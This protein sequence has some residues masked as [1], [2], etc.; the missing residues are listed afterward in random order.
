MQPAVLCLSSEP[1]GAAEFL[2]P[3][4]NFIVNLV[5]IASPHSSTAERLGPR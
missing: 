3:D 4:H 2:V 5:E 1:R